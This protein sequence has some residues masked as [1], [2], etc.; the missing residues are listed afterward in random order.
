MSYVSSGGHCGSTSVQQCRPSSMWNLFSCLQ[1][2][3]STIALLLAHRWWRKVDVGERMLG[4]LATSTQFE[5]VFYTVHLVA[6]AP[7]IGTYSLTV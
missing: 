2:D 7:Y 3:V 4:V 1:I 5:G 6:G